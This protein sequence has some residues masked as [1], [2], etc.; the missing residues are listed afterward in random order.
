MREGKKSIQS[1]FLRNMILI[2]LISTG[3]WC[4]IWINSEYSSFKAESESLRIE[5][6]ESQKQMLQF[7]VAGVVKHVQYMR[8]QADQKMNRILKNRVYEAHAIALNIYHKNKT[9]KTLHEIGDM[10]KEA[11]R[12]IR[13]NSGRGYYFAVSMDGVE[14]LYPIKP[15]FE[16]ESLIDL[17]DSKDNYV[18]RDEISIIKNLGEGFV[19]DFWMKPDEDTAVPSPKIS[20]V[21]YF[22]PL[23]WYF[24][25][26]EYLDNAKGQ[27]QNEVLN[28]ITDLRF[29]KDGYFFGSTFGGESLFSNGKITIDSGNIWNLTDPNGLKIIQEQQKAAKKHE[30][31][32]VSYSWR[33][34]DAPAPSPK[35]SY[36]LGIPE[37]KWTIGAGVYLDTIETTILAK[38]EILEN[39]LKK[40]L[41]NTFLILIALLLLI[42]FWSKQIAK[43]LANEIGTFSSS[44]IRSDTTAITI[45]TDKIDFQELK[46]IAELTNKMLEDR[47][48]AEHS[49]RESEA[50]LNASQRLTKTG[51][52][53][54]DV[55]KQ[56]MFWTQEVYRI[57]D[58]QPI[59]ISAGSLKQIE[60]GIECYDPVDRPV[61]MEAYRNCIEKGQAYDLEFPFTTAKGKQIW[62]RTIAEPI[63]K[64]GSVVKVIGN[65]MDITERKKAEEIIKRSE[66]MQSKMVA[67]IGDVIAIIDQDGINRYKST[68]IEKLFGWKPEDVVGASTWDNIHPDD[69][70]SKQKFIGNLIREPDTFGTMECR[71]KCKNGS[72]RWIEFT[73]SNLLHDPDIQGILGNYHDITVRKQ[74]ENSLR[75]SEARFKILHN[76]S[77]GG[78]AIHD[79]GIILDCNKGLSEMTGY[80]VA[81]LI[82]MDGLLLIA[83]NSRDLVM[84]NIVSGYEKPYEANGLRKNGEEFPMRLEARNIPHQKEKIRTVEFRDITE[85][86]LTEAERERLQEQ[87][88]QAQKMES[89]GILAGGIAHDFNNILF[90]IVG[91]TQMLM[92]DVPE[93]SPLRSS[94]DEIFA[95]SMRAKDLVKQI[96]TFSRQGSGELQPMKMQI[97]VSEALKLIRSSIPK[98]IEIKKNIQKD[99]GLIKADPTQIHQI[100]MNLTT[101]AYHAMEETGGIIEV[102]LQEVTIEGNEWAGE[103]LIAGEYALLSISDNGYG[104]PQSHQDKIF[105]PYFT[106]KGKDKG[107]G[108]GLS[109]VYG[110]VKEYGGEIKV[111][112][113]A[114][115]GTTFNVYIPL[116][117]KM[118]LPLSADNPEIIPT[119]NERILLVDD[120]LP[121]LSLEKQMLE[122]LGYSITERSSS[123]E[124][125]R[126]F[127]ANPDGFDLVV[128]DMAMPNMTGDKL[129][130]ELICIK[131]DIPIIICTGFSESMDEAF[132]KEMGINGFLMKPVIKSKMAKEVRKVLDNAM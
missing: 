59:K 132:A 62:I 129:A 93:D 130:K 74:A 85:Q 34:M 131:P 92:E 75:E 89:I 116:L 106:T 10:I 54:W 1:K 27:I 32:F 81:D 79:K 95:G 111:Y 39:S 120:E 72:Y 91:H 30:G 99:C 12:P 25:T 29:G 117:K 127:T 18:I 44:L 58:F 87:L 51:G 96:L 15:E 121:I 110:I 5:H 100:L 122:R 105:E 6:F 71:Y 86:K 66:S 2:A 21:K 101:N 28:S 41:I 35:I 13:F 118:A 125:L 3:L 82:G 37:W 78:I 52:W 16:G 107:T 109:I 113:E 119:G 61:I 84:K 49:L 90:P 36:V 115:K 60:R 73:G 76:A 98:S 63:R 83:E 70:E 102:R 55:E 17:Q 112:S 47:Q 22:K 108:L 26:G 56:T 46:E 4:V 31:G 33:K 23:D 57:H 68:N 114:G 45:N 14:Q 9:S 88:T 42:I 124:A 104:I 97:I 126:A 40:K 48:K 8:I 123:I 19:K 94:L 77:F 11:L 43:Q 20:F 24:G 53:E 69:L 128:T 7:E 64:D 103:L 38:R 65:L 50:L 67:N 80:S